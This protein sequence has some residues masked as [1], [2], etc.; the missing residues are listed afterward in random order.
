[1][2]ADADQAAGDAA[3]Q[4]ALN[5]ARLVMPLFDGKGDARATKQFLELV[6]SYQTV[7]RLTDAETARAVSFSMIPGSSAETWFQNLKDD[8]PVDV[9]NWPAL[10]Q[11]FVARFSPPLNPSEKG[12]VADCLLQGAKEDVYSFLDRCRAAQKLIFRDIPDNMKT[13]ANA[14]SYTLH[15]NA[16]ILEKFLRG[17]RTA[18]DF[19][20]KVNSAP[21]CTTLAH[22]REAALNIEHNM[23]KNAS[24]LKASI[25][26]LTAD[27]GDED[28]LTTP[29]AGDTVEVAALRQRLRNV[30]K[31]NGGGGGKTG[32]G[33]KN[34]GKKKGRDQS[35]PPPSPCWNCAETGHWNSDCPY[36]KKQKKG[37]A[38][39]GG[40][41]GGNQGQG[42]GQGKKSFPISEL[43]QRAM[44]QG[45]EMAY[46]Q[47]AMQQ[48]QQQ[49]QPQN[50]AAVNTLNA[51][52]PPDG[53]AGGWLYPGFNQPGF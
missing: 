44:L 13:G 5:K 26:A 7:T 51:I 38:D 14:A 25:N 47:M 36:P 8:E 31:G 48:Q 18:G 29:Q 20:E 3:A 39:G 9:L 42:Q 30:R 10:R 35:G 43:Q 21:G 49:Q 28:D 33:G 12:K 1:M 46:Q 27:D 11:H 19:K 22:F 41:G 16:A 2:D 40:G 4:A 53:T 45:M 6:D 34:A 32:G 17:L 52:Q 24:A 15:Q 37:A 23:A 50:N